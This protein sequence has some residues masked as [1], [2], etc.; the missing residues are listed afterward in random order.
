MYLCLVYCKV[1]W[2]WQTWGENRFLL[3]VRAESSLSRRS[4]LLSVI[5]NVEITKIHSLWINDC[6]ARIFYTIIYVLEEFLARKG[7]NNDTLAQWWPIPPPTGDWPGWRHSSCW[8]LTQ[9]RSDFWS[10]SLYEY[11]HSTNVIKRVR[12]SGSLIQTF[13]GKWTMEKDILGFLLTIILCIQ[14]PV[15]PKHANMLTMFPTIPTC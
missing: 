5:T 4:S 10:F 15:L 11:L 7:V 9:A 1:G 14:H 8:H 2:V 3:V 12:K 13:H 6:I